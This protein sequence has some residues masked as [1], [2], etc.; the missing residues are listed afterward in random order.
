MEIL[1]NLRSVANG[2]RIIVLADAL[3]RSQ[4]VE[5][6]KLGAR[7]L[8]LK[9]ISTELLFKGIRAVMGGEY[10]IDHEKLAALLDSLLAERTGSGSERAPGNGSC[11]SAREKQVVAAVAEGCTNKDIAERFSLSEETVKHH[12][13]HIFAKLGMSNRLELAFYAIHH[14]LTI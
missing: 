12:L 5:A 3:E 1:L 9:D 2:T 7:G 14:R 10:W 8:V 11:L 13:T 4:D 6:L